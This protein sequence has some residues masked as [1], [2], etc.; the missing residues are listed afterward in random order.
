LVIADKVRKTPEKHLFSAIE[1]AQRQAG[2]LWELRTAIDL[3]DLWQEQGR[4]DEAVSV[5]APAYNSI[6]DGDCP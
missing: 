3:A 2:K 5:L 6:A 1:V 4:I